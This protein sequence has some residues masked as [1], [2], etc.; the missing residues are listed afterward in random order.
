[1]PTQKDDAEDPLPSEEMRA[2]GPGPDDRT[3]DLTTVV[4][5]QEG[6][7]GEGA[8]NGTIHPAAVP[9][10]SS[11]RLA[12]GQQLGPYAIIRPLGRGGMGEVYE[13]IHSVSHHR[14]ALKILPREHA[15]SEERRKRTFRDFERKTK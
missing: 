7:V 15:W 10:D 1:M 2:P 4:P 8:V 3:V 13:A 5:Q 12:P 9:R 14:L 11:Y 6:T